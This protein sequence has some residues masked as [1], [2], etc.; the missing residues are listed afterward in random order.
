M[1]FPSF[2]GR[3]FGYGQV[4]SSALGDHADA[5]ILHLKSLVQDERLVVK[6]LESYAG[7]KRLPPLERVLAYIPVYF[8]LEEFIVA[9]KPPLVRDIYTKKGLRES[10]RKVVPLEQLLP[11]FRLIFLPENEQLVFL[12]EIGIQRIAEYAVAYIGLQ[13]ISKIVSASTYDTILNAAS[14]DGHGIHLPLPYTRFNHLSS[15]SIVSSFKTLYTALYKEVGKA[16]GEAKASELIRQTFD[17]IKKIY[18]FDLV[19]QFLRIVP[20]G[21]L[22]IE[23][24]AYLSRGELESRVRERTVELRDLNADL[25]R[26]VAERTRELSDANIR[27]TELDRIKTEFVS[28]AA[29]QLRTPLT[30][31]KWALAT[32]FEDQKIF[33][34]PQKRM[35]GGALDAAN[36]L[37]A[38]T[39]SL[40]D[41]SRIEKGGFIIDNKKQDLSPVV[42]GVYSSFKEAAAQKNIDFSLEV[43]PKLPTANFDREKITIVLNNVVDNAIKYT[44]QGGK[45]ALKVFKKNGELVVA[46]SDTGIGIPSR[47]RHR[48]FTAFYRSP[49]AQ[50]Y[51]TGGT[52]MG[53][54]LSKKIIEQHGGKTWFESE[55]GKGS[56]FYL[57]LASD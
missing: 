30:E 8:S 21:L 49:Q 5:V 9:N 18:E 10:V 17:F 3:F 24:L 6:Q 13:Q 47:E 37:I 36:Q 45:V 26:K 50:R 35:A 55:E 42:C 48:V 40:L 52:G 28:I 14:V 22:E 41:I 32:L 43:E 25:E 19:A 57:S 1:K 54:Y 38:L 34:I 4:S 15:E 7:A 27:L 44:L 31:I 56:T 16:F 53:L 20:D 12:Y 29:H 11:P 39:N 46:V 2:F 33:S 51:Q 23:Q